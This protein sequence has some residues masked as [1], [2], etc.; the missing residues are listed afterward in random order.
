MSRRPRLFLSRQALADNY[1]RLSSLLGAAECAA[2]IKAD[3]Y[4]LGV[5]FA[6]PVLWDAGCRTYFVAYLE[7]AVL[8]RA[9][10]PNAIIYV[11][12]GLAREELETC[13]QLDIRPVVNTVE[14]AEVVSGALLNPAVHI[15]TG[16]RRLGIP[17][18]QKDSLEYIVSLCKP[19]LLMSH[20]ASADEPGRVENMEQLNHFQSVCNTL[21]A[22]CPK[23]S[24]AN[25]AGIF[26][27]SAFHF[28]MARPGIG[29]YGGSP[30]PSDSKG[31]KPVVTW[32]AQILQ[33]HQ[34]VEGQSVGYGGDFLA[35]GDMWIATV[36][37]GYADGY[38]R[39]LSGRGCVSIEGH[40]CPLVG[41]VSMDLITVDVTSLVSEQ[42]QL[43][44]GSR[45]ELMG[46]VNSLDDMASRSKTIAYE[47]LTRLGSRLERIIV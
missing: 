10:L 43:Q 19:S 31:F 27:G 46:S 36:G 39:A 8:L 30:D 28:D 20:L 26:L 33:L 13:Q 37:S 15:D 5:D 42:S 25:T 17:M 47:C 11:F 41:R 22:Q 23:T 34:V 6:A 7:E 21:G 9:V 3:A 29:L 40:R 14:Q 32:E 44:V 18:Y 45:V 1:Q 16:M 38:P 24:L 12:H 35:R 4:G 2:S